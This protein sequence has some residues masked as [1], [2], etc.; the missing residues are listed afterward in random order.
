MEDLE[1]GAQGYDRTMA[2]VSL[3]GMNGRRQIRSGR[4]LTPAYHKN[5][6]PRVA[7]MPPRIATMNFVPTALPDAYVIELDVH[8]DERGSFTRTMCQE[9]FQTHGI[10][11]P[12]VQQNISFTKAK[13]TIRGMHFQCEPHSEGKLVRCTRG[14]IFDVIVDLRL[15]SPTYLSHIG[16]WLDESTPSQIYVPPGFAHGFQTLTDDVKMSYLLSHRYVPAA[17][18]GLSYQDPILDITWP[19]TVTT[20]S[21]RD[22]T[23]PRI[24]P[25]VPPS[26]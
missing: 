25:L 3:T 4:A 14:A 13:G 26:L 20:L 24:E 22:A 2:T 10:T 6:S 7:A 18:G 23:W 5:A 21:E 1:R 9:E 12:F 11:E 17:Q 19:L 8:E 16:F 15:E